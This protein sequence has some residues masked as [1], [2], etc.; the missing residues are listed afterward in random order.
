MQKINNHFF[1]SISYSKMAKYGIETAE[2]I[3]TV[4][5]ANRESLVESGASNHTCTLI[6][7]DEDN[8]VLYK[9]R[10]M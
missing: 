9:Q 2:I 6:V 7:G 1:Y 3:M 4:Q 10:I 5:L 8:K